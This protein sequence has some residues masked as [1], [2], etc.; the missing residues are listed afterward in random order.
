VTTTERL[1]ENA[2]RY[3]ASKPASPDTP[4]PSTGVAVVACMDAR[5]DVFALFGFSRGD[6]H[7]IRNAGGVVTDDVI[8]SLTISQ[9]FLG[10]KEIILVHHTQCGLQDFDDEA[11]AAE[12]EAETG[13]RPE[14]RARGFTDA[15]ADMRRSIEAIRSN[16]YIPS[17]DQV[18]GFVFD[19]V[20][21]RL[22]EVTA[23]GR[24]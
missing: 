20:D 18:R 21:G 24:G 13:S 9:R 7:V 11:F 23:E 16:P 2:E 4:R 14:W 1:L 6:A 17:R 5:L 19:V 10:T 8:R 22:H 12:L 3:A 15:A